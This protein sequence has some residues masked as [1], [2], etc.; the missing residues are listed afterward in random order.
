MGPFGSTGSRN[1]SCWVTQE[2]WW[3]LRWLSVRAPERL[4]LSIDKKSQSPWAGRFPTRAGFI[5]LWWQSSFEERKTLHASAQRCSKAKDTGS[6]NRRL[7]SAYSQDSWCF[8][9]GGAKGV[10]VNADLGGEC[11]RLGSNCVG[12]YLVGRSVAQSVCAAMRQ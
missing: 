3:N 6:A 11:G 8:I 4:I 5:V 2:T 12:Q 1:W 9:Q 10:R 7:R